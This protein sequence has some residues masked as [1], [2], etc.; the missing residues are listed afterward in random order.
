MIDDESGALDRLRNRI[1][2][3]ERQYERLDERGR[4]W[5]DKDDATRLM[6]FSTEKTEKVRED[7][8]SRLS[9]FRL[10]VRDA[11]KHAEKEYAAALYRSSKESEAS[12]KGELPSLIASTVAAVIAD[13]FPD[14]PKRNGIHPVLPY[15]VGGSALTT[16]VFGILYILGLIP[17]GAH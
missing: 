16:A 2:D 1:G 10:E 6:E 15:G 13:R 8:V 14:Q 17:A 9:D 4:G 3:L 7:F 5:L 12:L 11:F